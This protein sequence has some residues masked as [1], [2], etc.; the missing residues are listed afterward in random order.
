MARKRNLEGNISQYNSFSA[1]PV[2]DTVNVF[3]DMGVIVD[4]NDFDTFDLLRDLEQARNNLY[5]KQCDNAS[6]PQ[7]ET[8]EEDLITMR[9]WL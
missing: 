9:I 7:T 8:V 5:K 3:A 1:L 6:A 2:E 4:S